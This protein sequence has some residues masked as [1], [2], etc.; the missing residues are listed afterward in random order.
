M[1]S[2][3]TQSNS[4]PSFFP[5]LRRISVLW[6]VHEHSRPKKNTL[7]TQS[8]DALSS[9]LF[10]GGRDPSTTNGFDGP[11]SISEEP[12]WRVQQQP[13]P[14]MATLGSRQTVITAMI[15]LLC[16]GKQPYT[17]LVC[18]HERLCGD[19][20]TDQWKQSRNQ[21]DSKA[22]TVVAATKQ[23]QSSDSIE[24][25]IYGIPVMRTSSQS[26][27]RCQER[28]RMRWSQHSW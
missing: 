24:L 18:S 4:I 12:F 6:D 5:S 9:S 25:V 10:H 3:E 22:H 28:S 15:P 1:T 14:V 21:R 7:I 20:E 17:N 8:H 26:C 16:L 2:A 23:L 19:L 27:N 11:K 13:L